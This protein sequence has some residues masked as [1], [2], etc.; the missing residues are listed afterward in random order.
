MRGLSGHR[1]FA[2]HEESAKACMTPEEFVA[3][4]QD[5][6]EYFNKLNV[7]E[8]LDP[9]LEPCTNAWNVVKAAQSIAS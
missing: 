4:H 5:D 9:N 2:G 3:V 6:R 1:L 7:W 8:N